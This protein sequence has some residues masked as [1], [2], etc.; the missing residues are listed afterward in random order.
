MKTLKNWEK[1]A[2]DLDKYLDEPCEIDE[3]ICLYIAEVV[4]PNYLG[5]DN[6]LIQG[7]DPEKH[8]ESEKGKP[9]GYYMTTL[10]INNKHFY[11]GILPEFKR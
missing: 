4:S 5:W 3:D 10:S 11:L 7:G 6:G 9:I 8:E 2:V 1:Q